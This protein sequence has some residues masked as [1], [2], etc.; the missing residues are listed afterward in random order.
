MEKQIKEIIASLISLLVEGDY[1]EIERKTHRERLSAEEMKTAVEQYGKKL[2]TP[3]SE[4]Y[5]DMD[6]IKVKGSRIPQ[7][8]IS[9]P[10]WTMEEGVRTY[11]W[12]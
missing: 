7:W 2:V 8:S 12:S 1:S 6:V 4:A 10:L 9:M 5:N 11:L 3:P